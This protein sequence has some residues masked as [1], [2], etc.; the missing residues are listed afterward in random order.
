MRLHHTTPSQVSTFLHRVDRTVLPSLSSQSKLFCKSVGALNLLTTTPPLRLHHN[1]S[2][3]AS[4]VLHRVGLTTPI[5]SLVAGTIVQKCGLASTDRYYITAASPLYYTVS[6]I[7]RLKIPACAVIF[8]SGV[9]DVGKGTSLSFWWENWTHYGTLTKAV[10]PSGPRALRLL[11]FTTIS[12]ACNVEGWWLLPNPR[13]DEALRVIDRL[14]PLHHSLQSW[15][16]LHSWT[17][18]SSPSAP[19]L[20]MQTLTIE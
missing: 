4:T 20:H 5:P 18:I 11:L 15:V 6:N 8:R 7:T 16:E 3:Q 2:S 12:S 10:G 1:T 17:R 14:G 19:T 9:G 13:S